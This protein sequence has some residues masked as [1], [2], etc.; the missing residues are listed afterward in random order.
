MVKMK[1]NIDPDLIE[2][3][4]DIDWK[5]VNRL[6][7]KLR[8][9][10]FDAKKSNRNKGLSNLQKMML[11]STANILYSIRKISYN[12]SKMT[13]GIDG[14]TLK[15]AKDRLHLFNDIRRNK[16]NGLSPK[17]IK[18][19]YIK[20]ITKLRPISIPT[21]YDRV[22]QVMVCNALEPEWEVVFEKGSYGFR[23]KRNTNDA[24]SRV[25][26]GLNKPDSRK[27]IVYSDISKCFD[28]IL[29][30]YILNKL[31]GFPGRG[32]IKEMLKIG[33]FFNDVWIACDGKSTPE[34]FSLSFLLCNIALHGLEDELGVKYTKK[35]YVSQ[36]ARLLIRFADKL[37]ILCNTRLDALVALEN[38]K[39]VLIKRGL[40]TSDLKTKIVH[41][42]EGFDF[43]DYT[44][45]MA[46]K[47]HVY[48]NNAIIKLSESEYKIAHKKVGIYV[49]PSKKSIQDVK[50]KLK[51]A[52]MSSKGCTAEKFI[53]KINPIIRSYALSKRH[54]HSN[55]AF[56][57]IDNY[58]YVLC[59]RWA[60]RMHPQ[61]G[62]KWIKKKYFKFL[63]L[64]NMKNKWVFTANSSKNTFISK[65]NSLIPKKI[66]LYK[67]YWFKI[68]DYL[69]GRMDKL[70]DN[71]NDINYYKDLGYRRLISYPFNIFRR[72]NKDIAIS[73]KGLCPICDMDLFN[74]EKIHLHHITPKKIGGETTFGNLVYLH[75][76]C[77]YKIHSNTDQF[78]NYFYILQEYKRNH[79]RPN[80]YRLSQGED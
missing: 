21:V 17:P 5:K 34:A 12:S 68:R 39:S 61:K 54:W 42:S 32:L 51:E 1:M 50:S 53:E 6:V 20:D 52:L 55:K 75:T 74:G 66:F 36:K 31:K 28:S 76:A 26:L 60:V 57:E 29:H 9:R 79:P 67:T 47:P 15:C 27:W 58:V 70:P 80:F 38:L 35:S 7:T 3:W 33:F 64:G 24:V 10:I 16:W 25:W 19:I 78:N 77:H 62:S 71:R 8:R 49:V 46:P 73:Q 11:N 69:V 40:A 65:S 56:R 59:W 48:R 44:I 18:R 13:Q 45:K 63:K 43:L 30:E 23:P 4:S 37:V 72:L 22:I 2:N 41:I 14:E